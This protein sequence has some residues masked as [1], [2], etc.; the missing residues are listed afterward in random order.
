MIDDIKTFF[1]FL[2]KGPH[3]YSTL[4]ALI[5]TKLKS[6]KDGPEHI[7]IA[8]K[9]CEKNVVTSEECLS[10]LGIDSSKQDLEEA[11]T[12]EYQKDVQNIINSSASD[13]GGSGHSNLIYSICEKLGVKNA[14]ETG[15][16]YG[17]SSAA[18]LNSLSKRGGKLISIDMPMLRQTDYN[19]IG[20][21]VESRVQQNWD[22]VRKPDRYG[23]PRAISKMESSLDLVHYDSDKS[24][25]GRK[26]SQKLIWQNLSIGGIFISD[27]IEDNAAF[28]EFVSEYNLSCSVLE[29]EGKYVGVVK[30]LV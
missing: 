15:V 26:W 1:W 12:P 9:W 28:M 14:I 3:F 4:F 6:N 24:Y 7:K 17:W 5:Y 16:A 29:F 27:D 8:T 10:N 20:I 30:K 13:F 18:I 11:F 21:A 25:Y 23:L 2:M 22:L 19:L